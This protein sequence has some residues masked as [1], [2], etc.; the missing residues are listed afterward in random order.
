MEID[1]ER[2]A[3]FDATLDVLNNLHAC[4][5]KKRVERVKGE[6]VAEVC[7][8]GSVKSF[9]TMRTKWLNCLANVW[10]RKSILEILKYDM[11]SQTFDG[12]IAMFQQVSEWIAIKFH[13]CI[14]KGLNCTPELEVNYL[15]HSTLKK[16]SNRSIVQH[17]EK[18]QLPSVNG[19][20]LY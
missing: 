7:D 2:K 17:L 12:G 3:N 5:R 18:A 14:F 10:K 11:E 1:F 15:C 19:T 13:M 4:S 9:S 16:H 20:Y 6:K 8:E